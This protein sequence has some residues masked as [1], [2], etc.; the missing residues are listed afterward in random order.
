MHCK[1]HSTKFVKF[2][3]QIPIEKAQKNALKLQKP[4]RFPGK[5]RIISG[6]MGP[7]LGLNSDSQRN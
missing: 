4:Y 6:Y 7:N 5:S 2:T 3:A 1:A